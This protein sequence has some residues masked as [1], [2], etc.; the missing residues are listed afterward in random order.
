MLIRFIAILND[1]K[2]NMIDIWK[3]IAIILLI[4]GIDFIVWLVNLPILRDYL[5]D[6][7]YFWYMRN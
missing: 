5:M 3:I 2:I 7:G 1:K 4:A 6:T